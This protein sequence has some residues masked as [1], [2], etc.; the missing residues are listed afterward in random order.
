MTKQ[1]KQY[2][3]IVVLSAT[4]YFVFPSSD[5]PTDVTASI[6]ATPALVPKP[7]PASRPDSTD[8]SPGTINQVSVS[9]AVARPVG[10]QLVSATPPK[11]DVAAMERERWSLED[12]LKL[13]PT[14]NRLYRVGSTKSREPVHAIYVGRSQS[15]DR[16]TSGAALLGESIIKPG[17]SLSDGRHVIGIQARGIVIATPVAGR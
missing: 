10:R 6:A 15:G 5:E 1:H 8:S 2:A 4:L 13:D 7:T 12:V 11:T 3:L 16:P 9:A 17:H 14:R